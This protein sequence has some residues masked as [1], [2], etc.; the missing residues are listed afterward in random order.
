VAERLRDA[1]SP[2]LRQHA[3]DPVDW[4]PWC[5]EAFAEA[6][7]RD[8]PV[9][10]SVGYAA[11]HWCH[12]MARE[13]F[14][15]P[16]VVERLNRDFVAVK[17]DRE[18]RPDVDAVYQQAL[19]LMGEPGGW[20]LTLFLTPEGEPLWGGTYFP[21]EPRYGR[22]GFREVLARVAELW[23]TRRDTLLAQRD[24]LV[25]ALR[26]LE[27]PAPGT[28]GP[29]A[30]WAAAETAFHEF[31]PVHGGLGRAPKF[32][33]APV[34]R[35]L[36]HATWHR[37]LRPLRRR[38]LHTLTRMCQGGIWD[39][40]GGGF[41]RYAVDA[42]WLVPH[43]E[44]MLDD[45]AQLLELLAEAAALTGRRLF[46]V[47]AAELVD[48]LVREMRT[49]G[50]GFAASL[51][52]DSEGEEGRFYVWTLAEIEAELGAEDAALFAEAHGV[53]RGGNFEGRNVLHRL[54]DPDLR[55]EAEEA[56]LADLRR[57]LLR[58]R[59]RRPRPARDDK[60]LAD[61]N[62]LAVAALVAAGR[63]LARPDWIALAGQVFAAVVAA[64]DEDGRLHH[65][66]RDD[67]RTPH[68][69]L[70]DYAQMIRAAVRLHEATGDPAPLAR[71][72]RWFAV[73]EAR[74][75][76]G[77]GWRLVAADADGPPVPPRN[78]RDGAGP[79]PLA[80]LAEAA[81]ML[82]RFT[83]DET[84]RVRAEEILHA[85]GG[86]AARQPLAHA[87]LLT[88]GL[89]LWAPV[90]VTLWEGDD[91]D[92]AAALRAVADRL[93]PPGHHLFHVKRGAAAPLSVTAPDG[94]AA[95][96][97]RGHRCDPPL[98][99]PAALAAALRALDPS[100]GDAATPPPAG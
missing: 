18:E 44:K 58:A 7:R 96:V 6:R 12:V 21:P 24:A 81:L 50:G 56:R 61:W 68:D 16:D 42:A 80:T 34:L 14:R 17:V 77:D 28:L 38:L 10:L 85:H 36:W 67:R 33:Q 62:G 41:H 53:T 48:W 47:R 4:W 63:R 25:Q 57:R 31:D 43:F 39:H 11:C 59:A 86:D 22:P 35:L 75:R 64:L 66:V 32:P 60:V 89:A 52:A 74:F 3:D 19:A 100:D 73:A 83:G 49:E 84:Y 94:P 2:Y 27:R 72:R 91:P 23:R 5:P 54:H 71:A 29:D 90:E 97:C 98:R 46:A 13:S 93:A 30:V 88:A 51:D 26:R 79:A 87:A 8:V 76:D 55:R 15:D 45:N 69:L 20:P 78:A 1:T 92:A 95:V 99:D 82:A 40:L 37:P 70:G 9:L 65:A